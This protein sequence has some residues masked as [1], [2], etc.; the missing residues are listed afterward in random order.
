[1]KPDNAQRTCR[2]DAGER[3]AL[4]AKVAAKPRQCRL[5]AR[6]KEAFGALATPDGKSRYALADAAHFFN[7]VAKEKRLK[8]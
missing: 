7:P 4:E 6:K 8:I 3:R 1:L 5:Q 2:D